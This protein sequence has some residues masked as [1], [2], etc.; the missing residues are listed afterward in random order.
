MKGAVFF[1]KKMN[2]RKENLAQIAFHQG[3]I[4]R[5]EDENKKLFDDAVAEMRNLIPHV[6][7]VVC[8]NTGIKPCQQK[9]YLTKELALE[10]L[11]EIHFNVRDLYSVRRELVENIDD[12]VLM[13]LK[14]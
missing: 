13:N 1:K 2:Q 9:C 8:K 7:I 6:F 3:E 14:E 5:L 11:E 4:T 10:A 12:A